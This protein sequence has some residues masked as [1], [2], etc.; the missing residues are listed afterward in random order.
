M[1][2][3]LLSDTTNRELLDHQDWSNWPTLVYTPTC[4]KK[5]SS[6]HT[7]VSYSNILVA[8]NIH[9]KPTQTR[10]TDKAT[11]FSHRIEMNILT[12]KSMNREFKGL[13][14]YRTC[15]KTHDFRGVPGV[16]RD[17]HVLCVVVDIN[18]RKLPPTSIP[19]WLPTP[20]NTTM[21]PT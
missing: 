5:T 10:H 19:D 17:H 4:G 1:S 6:W 2:E 16:T 12:L 9:R 3:C 13:L 18:S 20:H 21:W 7:E 15:L 14:T 8:K 11:K